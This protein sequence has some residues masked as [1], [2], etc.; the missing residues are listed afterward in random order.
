MKL[1]P[2]VRL[3]L[4]VVGAASL[5][6]ACGKNGSGE[7]ATPG[8]GGAAGSSAAGAHNAGSGGSRESGGTA[9]QAGDEGAG[10]GGEANGRGGGQGVGGAAGGSAGRRGTAG[11]QGSETAGEAGAGGEAGALGSSG[12]GAGGQAGE[13]PAPVEICGDGRDNDGDLLVDCA[14]SDCAT[15]PSCVLGCQPPAPYTR[16]SASS[17]GIPGDSLVLWLRADVGLGVDDLTHVCVWE[18][19]SGKKNDV[20]QPTAT[21]RPVTGVTL[22]TRAALTFTTNT[23]LARGDVLGMAAAS[24]RTFFAVFQRSDTTTRGTVVQQGESGTPGTYLGIDTNT[25]NTVGERFGCYLTNNAYDSDVT[26][27]LDPHLHSLV[28]DG[29]TP[30]NDVLAN[31]HYRIDAVTRTLTRTSGGLGNGN[32]EDF[33]GANFTNIGSSN[34]N[35]AEVIAYARPLDGADLAAVES[36]LAV[37]YGISD[38]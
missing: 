17:A 36:Y 15:D 18:D 19:Q 30:G 7:P 9:G 28:F 27:D 11:T 8:H 16:L 12:A 37:R 6:Y 20:E 1:L 5:L 26:T 4:S 34:L 25:F 23:N 31:T 33:S 22:G 14:D 32:I 38:D 10:R 29:L 3:A 35:L 13:G 21:S 2:S 24:G